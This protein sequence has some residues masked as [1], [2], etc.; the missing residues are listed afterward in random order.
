[1]K[2]CNQKPNGGF[3]LVELVVVLAIISIMI[4]VLA[5]SARVAFSRDPGSASEKLSSELSEVRTVCMAKGG[6]VYIALR[7]DASGRI[8]SEVVERSPKRNSDGTLSTD[9][10]GAVVYTEKQ[11]ESNDLNRYRGSV[12]FGTKGELSAAKSSGGNASGVTLR[13]GETL[14]IS[15]NRDSGALKTFRASRG[16]GGTFGYQEGFSSGNASADRSIEI[17]GNGKTWRI[18]ID[19]LTGDVTREAE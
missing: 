18:T 13:N 8:S 11:I 17:S 1:M 4:T 10:S 7:S 3:T 16:T 2:D 6:T 14:Y 9:D 19:A 12:R 5:L 15:F